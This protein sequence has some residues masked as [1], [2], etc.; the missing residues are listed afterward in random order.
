MYGN[1]NTTTAAASA[2]EGKTDPL[3]IPFFDAGRP[4]VSDIKGNPAR[5]D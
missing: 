4:P 2:E 3:Q 1:T 5:F